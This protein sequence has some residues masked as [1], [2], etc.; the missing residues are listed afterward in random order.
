[1]LLQRGAVA[2]LVVLEFGYYCDFGGISGVNK[3]GLEVLDVLQCT[4]R[5]L[6]VKKCPASCTTFECPTGYSFII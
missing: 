1:M 5:S 4:G 3:A 2:P 6:E